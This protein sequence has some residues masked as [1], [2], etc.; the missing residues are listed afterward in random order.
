MKGKKRVTW[1]AILVFSLMITGLVA[2]QSS[3]TDSHAWRTDSFT[4]TTPAAPT[5]PPLGE[6]DPPN[7]NDTVTLT[8]TIPLGSNCPDGAICSNLV[9][10]GV[11]PSQIYLFGTVINRACYWPGIAPAGCAVDYSSQVVGG[12][13]VVSFTVP[14]ETYLHLAYSLANQF[15]FDNIRINGNNITSYGVLGTAP[16]QWGVACF[17]VHRDQAGAVTV[18]G[19]PACTA[20]ARRIRIRVTGDSDND[21]LYDPPPA[22]DDPII[23]YD[24][25]D[26][27]EDIRFQSSLWLVTNPGGVWQRLVWDAPATSYTET[28]YSVL[29]TMGAWFTVYRP[30]RDPLAP[31]GTYE[32]EVGGV[33]A[34]VYNLG[35]GAILCSREL[36]HFEDLDPAAT[37]WYGALITGIDAGNCVTQGTDTRGVIVSGP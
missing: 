7:P 28:F 27:R 3:G 5:T 23:P 6:N 1:L 36:V 18:G 17:I 8:M 33:F 16:N 15:R 19:N 29:T 11:P 25:V 4:P 12:N 2:C 37:F 31:P 32:P 26:T 30:A 35:G 21:G 20:V 22:F 24:G 9:T 34:D 14:V 10:P 13:L